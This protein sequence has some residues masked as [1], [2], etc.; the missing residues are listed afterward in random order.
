MVRGILSVPLGTG[1]RGGVEVGWYSKKQKK[2]RKSQKSG[3]KKQNAARKQ[4][5]TRLGGSTSYLW[6]CVQTVDRP[7]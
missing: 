3:R 4:G 5:I 2:G 6:E 7:D 1:W